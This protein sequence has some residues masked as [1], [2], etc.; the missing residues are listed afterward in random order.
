MEN[1]E[2]VDLLNEWFRELRETNAYINPIRLTLDG[3]FVLEY[4]PGGE[5][6]SRYN[7]WVS[8]DN[9]SESVEGAEDVQ[10]VVER[11]LDS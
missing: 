2:N 7:A 3:R 1:W 8:Y 6:I 10:E 11:V 9:Y 4:K 5:T